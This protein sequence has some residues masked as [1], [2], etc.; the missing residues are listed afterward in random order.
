[1]AR[2]YIK[3]TVTFWYESSDDEFASEVEAEEFGWNYDQMNYDGV[4]EITVEELENEEEEDE[5]EA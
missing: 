2:H 4:Y 1:M 3:T 5:D